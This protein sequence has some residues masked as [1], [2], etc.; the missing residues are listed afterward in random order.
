M[1]STDAAML[2]LDDP[3]WHELSHAY[4]A[5]TDIAAWLTE[6][7]AANPLCHDLSEMHPWHSLC[8]QWTV[9]PATFAAIPHVIDV[10]SQHPAAD[11]SRIALLTFVGW[12]VAITYLPGGECPPYL[13]E[14]YDDAVTRTTRLICESLPFASVDTDVPFGFRQL[15]ASL[16][17][18]RG[19]APIAFVLSEINESF[20]CPKCNDWVRL[21]EASMN[22]LSDAAQ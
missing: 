8:H 9:Y 4:G 14:A 7:R 5:G 22:P 17:A 21:L 3:R 20:R 13:V 19:D 6:L 1:L 12:C 15:L 11:Q 2:P 10:V 18:C 16:A